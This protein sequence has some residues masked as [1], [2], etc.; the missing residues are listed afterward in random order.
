MSTYTGWVN[1]LLDVYAPTF[2]QANNIAK[3]NIKLNP[4]QLA[5]IQMSLKLKRLA[6][7]SVKFK[8]P[9]DG[10]LFDTTNQTMLDLI[11]THLDGELNL[12][13]NEIALEFPVEYTNGIVGK[14]IVFAEQVEDEIQL[15]VFNNNDTVWHSIR[16]LELSINRFTHV[17]N[18]SF[19]DKEILIGADNDDEQLLE[20][21]KIVQRISVGAVVQLLCALSCKNVNISDDDVKPSAVKQQIRKSKNK[22]PFFT[23][24]V[25]TI[26]VNNSPTDVVKLS[27]D[28]NE[29]ENNGFKISGKRAHL[30]RGHPRT[31]KNGVTIWV[32]AC[33]P[34]SKKLGTVEKSYNIK[35]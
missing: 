29:Y 6:E 7:T 32:K 34:G 9:L 30:R 13:F 27:A 14:Y 20:T 19:S 15:L 31:Y 2:K 24:K 17:L 26:H 22:L 8:L 3:S 12:P 28:V 1:D 35:S 5:L 16:G 25:L 18:L 21:A 4:V 33:A 10:A 11:E 23:Y